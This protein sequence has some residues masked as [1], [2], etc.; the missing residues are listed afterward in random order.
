MD[1]KTKLQRFRERVE[2]ALDELLPPPG[3][4]PGRLHEAMRYS[5]E[6]GG[7]R[8]RPVLVI[9]AAE[10]VPSAHDPLPAAVAVEC[11]HAYSLIHD[12]LPCMDNGDLRRGRPSCHR[13]Y[14]EATAV[15]A[16]DAL[17]TYAFSLL[18]RHYRKT[19]ALAVGLVEDL[20]RAAG[21]EKLIGGQMEDIQAEKAGTAD[22]EQIDFIHR[23]KTAALLT[24][25]LTM[26]GRLSGAPPEQVATL[27]QIGAHLG[28][29][30]QIIDDV[31]DATGDAQTLGKAT[32]A[33]RAA[34]KA[35]YVQRHGLDASRDEARRHTG[36]A[37]ERC[38]ELA[39]DPEFL[40]E[41]IRSL[42]HRIR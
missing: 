30:Y 35:T 2:A 17:N 24:A 4:R 40:V 12:D 37:T 9:A 13:R 11:I 42:E 32:G 39:G 29:A 27:E 6:S 33:D 26:G 28:I 31:L 3:T 20:A 25:A 34:E 1:L 22:A 41:L 16:G 15:L 18:A 21:S 7:K 14:D 5:A 19:P 36:R 23:N 10:L 38:G 8:L